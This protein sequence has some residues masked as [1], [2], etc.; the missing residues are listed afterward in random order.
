[1]L[2][3]IVGLSDP[4]LLVALIACG[5]W[6]VAY[7]PWGLDPSAGASLAGALFGG[8]AVLLGN[9]INRATSRHRT[10]RETED[11]RIKLKTLIAAELVGV[12]VGLIGA[13]KLMDAAIIS[14]MA[15]G[16]VATKLD[17]DRY[18]PRA[19]PFTESLGTELLLLEHQAIDAL[20]TLRSNLAITQHEM[21]E[22]TAGATFGL[23]K[24]TT[25]SNGLGHDMTVLAETLERIAPTRKLRLTGKEPELAINILKRAAQPP[26]DYLS[27]IAEK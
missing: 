17:M 24:A 16:S 2:Y 20:T 3:R 12:A 11:R 1:M 15:Q 19:M 25:L 4:V 23:L 7:R 21:D 5:I 6:F 22:I 10:I 14:S 8:A 27:T 18:R 26:K 9:W 13:K